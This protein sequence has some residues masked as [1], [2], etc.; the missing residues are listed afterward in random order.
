MRADPL[1]L[2]VLVVD[3]CADTAAS[4]G[5]LLGLYGY[6]VRTARG[7]PAALA[8]LDGWQPDVALLDLAMPEMSGYELARRVRGRRD[9]C[10]LLVAVTGLGTPVHRA[11]AADAGF[12]HFLLKPVNPDVMSAL[13]RSWAA[14]VFAPVE[15]TSGWRPELGR[16]HHVAAEF[17]CGRDSGRAHGSEVS[18]AVG[19]R[20]RARPLFASRTDRRNDAEAQV[21]AGGDHI[22]YTTVHANDVQCTRTD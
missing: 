22:A 14:A 5:E 7:G 1:P 16:A 19:L 18:N 17:A 12:D 10:P 4:C 6:D 13:L 15:E 8:T 21:V 3:D 2:A 11:R 20:S 9:R